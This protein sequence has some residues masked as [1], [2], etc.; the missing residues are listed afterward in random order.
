LRDPSGRRLLWL[1]DVE[2]YAARRQAGK[3][4]PAAGTGTP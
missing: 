3:S 4:D 1:E 2:A